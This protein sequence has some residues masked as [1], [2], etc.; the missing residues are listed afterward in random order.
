MNKYYQTEDWLN[1]M[2]ELACKDFMVIDDFIDPQLFQTIRS[3]FLAHLECFSKAAIGA[4]ENKVI[5]NEIRGDLSYW[6]DRKRDTCLD[7][8]WSMVDEMLYIFNRYCF[9]GLSGYEFHLTNY[10]KGGHYEKHI[11]QFNHRSNRTISVII[12]LNVGWQK[13][14]GGELEVFLEDGTSKIIEP[15]GARCV[16]FKSDKVPHQVLASNKPRYSLTGWLLKK[17]S[18]LGQLLG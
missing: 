12:Y 5:R 14:D 2:D 1:W 8:F 9:L 6:L 18:A 3:F 7:D 17:P 16:M 11:D 13:G 4:A 10:P 15:I